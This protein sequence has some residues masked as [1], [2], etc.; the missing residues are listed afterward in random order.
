MFRKLSI[1]T[2]FVLLGNLFLFIGIGHAQIMLPLVWDNGGINQSWNTA[3]LR[4][5]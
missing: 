5:V 4:S 1:M 2:S 3:K